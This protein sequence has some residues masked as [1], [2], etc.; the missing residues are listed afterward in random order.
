MY[1]LNRRSTHTHTQT[2]SVWHQ[3]QHEVA[4]FLPQFISHSHS[5]SEDF[6]VSLMFPLFRSIQYKLHTHTNSGGGIAFHLQPSRRCNV[7]GIL[8]PH[9]HSTLSTCSIDNGKDLNKSFLLENLHISNCERVCYVAPA[10]DKSLSSNLWHYK[11]VVQIL[12]YSKRIKHDIL[13]GLRAAA[14]VAVCHRTN[15]MGQP[16]RQ[17][18]LYDMANNEYG[19]QWWTT[20]LY[21][22]QFESFSDFR[23][24]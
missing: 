2:D 15:G 13:L 7:Y 5:G 12:H 4:Q 10:P 16:P 1:M 11:Y 3:Q 9:I 21:S 23:Y 19:N 8:R 18:V 14:A 20:F 17:S 24:E 22:A 6:R